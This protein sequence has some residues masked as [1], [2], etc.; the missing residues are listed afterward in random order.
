MDII[1]KTYMLITSGS[2]WIKT[3]FLC[4][5]CLVLSCN[6]CAGNTYLVDITQCL[7][8]RR[9]VHLL[10]IGT[11]FACQNKQ[12]H[13]KVSFLNKPDGCNS[14]KNNSKQYRDKR[15][16]GIDNFCTCI[17]KKFY[18]PNWF[19]HKAISGLERIL[20][21]SQWLSHLKGFHSGGL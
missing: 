15:Y 19:T 11:Q 3:S 12:L 5:Q 10:V 7:F 9:S 4:I 6:T 16:R 17:L 14:Q 20:Q 13:F 21:V 2:Y 1:G 8:L 18:T